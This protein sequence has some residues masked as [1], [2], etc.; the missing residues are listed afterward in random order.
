MLE[1]QDGVDGVEDEDGGEQQ[2]LDAKLAGRQERL[3]DGCQVV[4][5]DHESQV[6]H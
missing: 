3:Q 5:H 2:Q 1:D 4:D 6:H